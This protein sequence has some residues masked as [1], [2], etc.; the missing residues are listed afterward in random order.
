MSKQYPGGLIT[1]SPVTPAGPYQDGSAP[2]IWT[3]N[4][5]AY[6]TKQG[7]WPTAGN[8]PTDPYFEYVTM[9][10][11]G[12][13]SASGTTNVLPFN[14]DAST[15]A[16][17]FAINGDARSNNFNPYQAGY[18]SNY[19]DGSGDYLTAASNAAFGFGTGDFTAECWVY[20]VSW[21]G[22]YDGFISTLNSGTAVGIHLSRDGVEVNGVATAW[23]TTLSL[24]TW[25]H[26]ALTRSGT[27]LRLFVNGALTNSGTNSANIGSSSAFAVGRRLEDF[28]NYYCN[29]YISNARIVKGTAVYTSAF[30]P[31]TTPLT[32]ISGTSVLTC[33]SNRFIDTSTNNFTITPNG[34]TAVSPAQPFT[35]PT[36][37]ATY[38]SGYFD[39]TGD[40]LTT[41]SNTAFA[42]GTG[43]FTIEFWAYKTANTS[44]NYDIAFGTGDA[45]TGNNGYF[46]ELSSTRGFVF[47]SNN[48]VVLSYSMNPNTSAWAHYAVTR[49]GST[50][51]LFV[52]GAVVTS[53]TYS[54]SLTSTVAVRVGGTSNDFFGYLSDMRVVKGTAVYTTTYTLPTAPLTA[55]SG[56]S[57]LTTQYNGAGNNNGF[58]DSSQNNFVITRS[59]NTTQG[60]F[61]PYGANWSNYFDGSGDYLSTPSS[62]GFDFGTGDF[63]VEAWINTNILTGE[64][65]FI[66]T[67][68]TAGGLQTSYTNG[69]IAVV[70]AG[71]GSYTINVNIGGTNVAGS[72]PVTT[73]TWYH[74]A[75]TRSSGVVR[76][77]INGA[78]SGGPTTI[79]ANLNGTY[80]C[81]GGYYNGSYLWSGYISNLRVVK[82][83]AVYTAAFTPSTTPLTAISGTS[84][85]TCADNRFIDDSTN[86]FTLTRNGDVSVQRFS[87]FNPTSAYS[88]SSIGGSAY[89]DGSGDNLK[90]AY[91]P[92]MNLTDQNFAVEFWIYL[93][94]QLSN[95]SIV[96][97]DQSNYQL[98]SY[99]DSGG[100]LTFY[101]YQANGTENFNVPMGAIPVRAWTHLVIAR[102]GSTVAGFRNGVRLATA[103][104]SGTIDAQTGGWYIG[105]AYSNLNQITGYLSD[106]RFVI[107]SNPYGVGTTLTVPTAPL[108]AITNTQFLASMT[109]AAIYDNA[110]ISDQETVGNAQ[111]STSIKKFGNGS[112]AF[113][114]TADRLTS[115]GNPAFAF[116]TGDFTIEGWFYIN[117]GSGANNGAFQFSANAGG[118]Q[119]STS[120]SIAISS[121][122]PG[123][124][125][126]W[127]IY[128]ANTVAYGSATSTQTWIYLALVRASGSLKLYINGTYDATFGT[129]TDTT[130]YTGQNLCV[131]GYYST[132]YLWNGYIDDFRVTKY[133]RYTANFTAPTSQFFDQ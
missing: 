63:T 12:N 41:A 68:A 97:Q 84:L 74:V 8:V 90:V 110:M 20:P 36:T 122:D 67:S 2:G 11:H 115:V 56:T 83:T 133:A 50:L 55:I 17:N 53:T 94:A 104:F 33:Q 54:T 16:F 4:Q 18:Y 35:L 80:A 52:N 58:K 30:T 91:T 93:P 116:G 45:G 118:L 73:E 44:G 108:T 128:Y 105:A 60:T 86:N 46:I 32:A 66:Q 125:N 113:D 3:L 87:P 31:S 9:L 77:F 111:I 96:C 10:L 43:D 69:V 71:A 51:R 25:T 21:V 13:G 22:L 88:T 89:Y 7:L 27:T 95:K 100:N 107:G 79:T 92:Q 72:I 120:N 65:G 99:V 24:D 129:K 98:N 37:V 123:G 62:S 48:A 131:G 119:A 82:G 39:G 117:S 126:V 103:T 124:G 121:A 49:S 130:N 109:N 70:A 102:T 127:G 132:A 15:N 38:G 75:F 101:S 5:A 14:S 28:N 40:N 47:A 81:V 106:V 26:L 59:G 78:L 57:L 64:K 85:L 29:A 19:F 114:G 23:G 1:K 112:L 61:T 6:W 42:F 34:N 76:S